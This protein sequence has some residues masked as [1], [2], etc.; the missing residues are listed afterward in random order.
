MELKTRKKFEWGQFGLHTFFIISCLTFILPLILMVSISLSDPDFKFFKLIPQEFSTYAYEAIFKKPQQIITAYGVTIF[1]SV[2]GVIT[3]VALNSMFAYSMSR[4]NFLFKKSLTVL[5]FITMVF[6]GGLVPTY[7]VNTTLLHLD[8]TMWIHI[9]PFMFDAWN[10]IVIR[11]FFNG[12][13]NDLFEAARLDGANE[14]KICFKI[15]MPMS[16]PILV[17][18]AYAKFLGG[19]NDW[20]NSSIY[21]RNPDLYS[22]Q[23]VLKRFMDGAGADLIGA[24]GT[25]STAQTISML[26]P[27]KYA[28]AILGMGPAILI[29]PFIQKYYDKGVIMG[30]LKG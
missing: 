1:Y 14:L 3:S 16:I 26:E 21:I 17:T 30:S 23:Y 20:I 18:I 29:F 27:V 5:L 10:I 22:L 12:L 4:K 8:D 9:L 28:M 25:L 24:S 15:A 13:P 7:L 19:W 6:S 2:A 11:T